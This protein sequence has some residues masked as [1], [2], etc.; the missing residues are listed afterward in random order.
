MAHISTRTVGGERRYDVCWRAH[1]K[2]RSKTFARRA[3]AKMFKVEI[4][5]KAQL[6]LLYEAPAVTLAAARDEWRARWMIGKADSTITRKD[7]AWPHVAAIE[8]VPLD[9]LRP[10]L[11]DDTIAAAARVA[12]RQAQ[13]ALQT[14]KQI[15]KD[16]QT[17]GQGFQPE[18]LEVTAPSYDEREPVFLTTAE[19]V[20]LGAAMPADKLRH[21]MTAAEYAGWMPESMRRFPVFAGLSG[22]RL[23]ELLGLCD[24]DVDLEDG[25]VLVQRSFMGRTKNRKRRRVYPCAQA[26]QILREQL[27][28]RA[29]NSR[30]LMFPSPEGL[31]W[32]P[33]NFRS[34]VWQPAVKR[35]ARDAKGARADE[36]A[37][38]TIHD[39]RHSYASLM[40][41][42]GASVRTVADQMGHS[43][44]GVL[45]LKRYGHLYAD[46]GVRASR[47]MDVMVQADLNPAPI[48]PASDSTAGRGVAR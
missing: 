19:L 15:L 31:M 41:R 43:D 37:R 40:L 35:L 10:A 17:R 32:N 38:L 20:E 36:I 42:S 11:L 5:R 26:V 48:L 12:P 16:A 34:R 2:S 1:G 25:S 29:P 4:E 14:V 24:T 8:H 3:D 46:A 18:L 13:I 30:G 27:L 45:V 39:L 22:L 21:Q 44:G 47:A 9:D 6:G 23:G 7:D 28:A 33:D